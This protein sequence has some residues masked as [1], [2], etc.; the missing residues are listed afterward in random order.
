MRKG[1][2]FEGLWDDVPA[3]TVPTT[4]VRGANSVFVADEDADEFARTAPAFRGVRVVENSGHSVQ[5]DQPRVLVDILRQVL[6]RRTA[7]CAGFNTRFSK[8]SSNDDRRKGGGRVPLVP[9]VY[10]LLAVC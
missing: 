10:L 2:G 5:S 3:L 7:D 4:L 6:D 1:E 9:A 8:S